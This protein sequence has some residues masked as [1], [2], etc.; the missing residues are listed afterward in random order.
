MK[1]RINLYYIPLNCIETVIITQKKL[2]MLSFILISIFTI[3]NNFVNINA[4][5]SAECI[6]HCKQELDKC[7]NQQCKGVTDIECI[8]QKCET[9][10][11]LC[12]QTEC[13]N[14]MEVGKRNLLISGPSCPNDVYKCEQSWTGACIK[15]KVNLQVQDG[16]CKK[17]SSGNINFA[18]NCHEEWS[19]EFSSTYSDYCDNTYKYYKDFK[20]N[21]FKRKMPIDHLLYCANTYRTQKHPNDPTIQQTWINCIMCFCLLDCNKGEFNINQVPAHNINHK[22]YNTDYCNYANFGQQG[23]NF[24]IDL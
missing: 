23:T 13:M 9:E 5:P 12:E 6:F 10:R 24:N 15:A 4:I 7:T 1:Y 2:N 17:S 19:S 3:L 8:Q 14:I 18:T 22:C 20:P 11:N 16:Q 21:N